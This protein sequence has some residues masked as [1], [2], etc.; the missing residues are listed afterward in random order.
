MKSYYIDAPFEKASVFILKSLGVLPLDKVPSGPEHSVTWSNEDIAREHKSS[1]D[2][3]LELT[4]GSITIDVRDISNSWI[5][6]ELSATDHAGVLIPSN[7]YRKVTVNEDSVYSIRCALSPTPVYTPRFAEDSDSIETFKYH[8]YR[9]LVCELCQQFFQ[10]GWVTGTGGS[11]S[12]KFGSRVYMTPSGVQ[13]ERIKPDELFVLDTAGNI[14]SVPQRKPDF[15]CPKLSDC[16]PLFLHA[17]QIRNA[18]N[19]ECC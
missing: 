9:E 18:G 4:S 17:Y 2:L 15:V 13:K 8:F 19:I 16:A 10:A 7:L 12:I 14:L 5:R 3:V 1:H 11:I 6:F